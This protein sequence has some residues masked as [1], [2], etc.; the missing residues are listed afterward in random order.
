MGRVISG[1]GYSNENESLVNI[2]GDKGIR[3]SNIAELAISEMLS[4]YCGFILEGVVT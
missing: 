3:S 4:R 1:G 2:S